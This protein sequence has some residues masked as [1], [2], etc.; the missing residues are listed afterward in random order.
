MAWVPIVAVW[1]GHAHAAVH[2]RHGS[3]VRNSCRWPGLPGGFPGI[4][5]CLASREDLPIVTIRPEVRRVEPAKRSRFLSQ[6]PPEDPRLPEIAVFGQSN[7]GKS[8]LVNFICGRKL[9]STISKHPGHTRLLHHFLVDKSWY[10][11]DLPGIGY[12]EGPGRKLKAMDSMVNA[13]VR[14]RT[15]LI[16][17][18]YLVDASK[19]VNPMDTHGIKWLTDAGVYLSVVFTKTDK[20]FRGYRRG[21]PVEALSKALYD[22][23]DSPWRFGIKRQLPGMFLTSSIQR[24]GR[25]AL[26]EHIADLRQRAEP[27]FRATKAAKAATEAQFSRDSASLTSKGLDSKELAPPTGVR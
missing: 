14:H 9:L 20:D 7:V 3:R 23:P 2:R 27:R 17:L 18:L 10:L 24:T 26:L 22:M 21:G 11:V 12:A 4:T 16:E 19:P 25:E 5:S 15:T 8:S 1:I 6:C 13:Y